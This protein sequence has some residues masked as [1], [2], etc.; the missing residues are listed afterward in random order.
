MR[1]NLILLTVLILTGIYYAQIALAHFTPAITADA[2]AVHLATMDGTVGSP[3]THRIL[4]PFLV[5]PFISD[6]RSM[7]LA[8]AVADVI[9]LVVFLL[10]L[11][12]WLRE[13]LTPDAALIGL[14]LTA[15]LLPMMF[16]WFVLATNT[17]VEAA[18]LTIGLLCL[19]RL[20]TLATLQSSLSPR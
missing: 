20:Y 5:N 11:D 12:Y 14:L 4:V 17:P 6:E 2:Y 9:A 18:L 15:L 13:W 10:A 1:R 8:Y 19:K 7:I 3:F 16:Q